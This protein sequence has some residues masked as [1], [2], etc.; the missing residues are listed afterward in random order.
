V[1]SSESEE[2]L[3]RASMREIW[4]PFY[5]FG[6]I[7]GLVL[8]VGAVAAARG[9]S[10]ALPVAVF[11]DL[12]CVAIACVRTLMWWWLP[13][14]VTVSSDHSGLFVRRDKRVLRHYPWAD[15][16][17]VRL[18]WGDRWPEWSRWAMFPYIGVLRR[19]DGGGALERSPAFLLV[20]VRDVEE[21]E[22]LLYAAVGRHLSDEWS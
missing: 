3:I 22:R 21:A 9:S 7:A 8:V 19:G 13:A 15:V 5:A 1:T 18:T 20:R 14:R 16:Q 12:V 11:V 4:R 10:L 2:P 6:V 17:Q